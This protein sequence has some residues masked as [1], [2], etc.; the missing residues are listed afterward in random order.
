M[1]KLMRGV[2]EFQDNYV[3]THRSF[4]AQLAKG[5]SP[6]ILFIT[7][8]D[9]RIDPELITQAD[10]GEL[11]VIRNAGNLV[12]P[13]GSTNGGEGATIE[14]A[15]KSLSVTNIIVCG[16]SS[17][18]AMKG[19]LQIGSLEE[20]MP[21]VYNW[22]KHTEATRQLVEDH[23]PHL[24]KQ[25]KL[26]MLVAENVLTQLENLR[27]YPA[28]RSQLHHGT[29]TLHGWIY[30]ID[31]GEIMA[32]DP[33]RHSFGAPFSEIDPRNGAL[34]QQDSHLPGSGRLS[35][36]QADRIYRGSAAAY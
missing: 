7:C 26:E 18:G 1:K 29:L 36:Q 15:L 12:P 5:Q 35:A 33:T 9:S 30:R 6:N 23:Y 11:F 24:E 16:H 34:P 27:T 31:T 2:R 20:K 10:L 32:Y 22:L 4:L 21:L 17:C 3:P 13:Y 19:L 8:S 14:Y 25:E 28:V